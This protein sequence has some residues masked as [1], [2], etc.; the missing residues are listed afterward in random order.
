[1]VHD[2]RRGLGM[3]PQ[4]A[5]FAKAPKGD[6]AKMSEPVQVYT[7]CQFV[8]GQNITLNYSQFEN[9]SPVPPVANSSTSY[10]AI[11]VFGTCDQVGHK[12]F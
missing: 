3:L 7:A 2:V 12:L 8:N 11:L 1:M 10:D 9:N 4:R 6:F 5:I